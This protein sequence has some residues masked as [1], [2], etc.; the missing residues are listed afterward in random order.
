[1]EK[2]V[3]AHHRT[4]TCGRLSV[5]H[6]TGRWSP[7]RRV[8]NGGFQ[9]TM[10]SN[11]TCQPVLPVQVNWMSLKYVCV[12]VLTVCVCVWDS[13]KWPIHAHGCGKNFLLFF[14]LARSSPSNNALCRPIKSCTNH[15]M[16]DE[17]LLTSSIP[18]IG[19]NALLINTLT[20]LTVE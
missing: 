15:V 12:C 13:I 4:S 18:P 14:Y 3:A 8:V 20:P 6:V 1:M 17:A 19:H 5:N 16:D 11:F 9:H 7:S 2:G 10:S